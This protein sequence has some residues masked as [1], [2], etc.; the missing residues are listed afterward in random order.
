[1]AWISSGIGARGHKVASWS[2]SRRRAVSRAYGFFSGRQCDQSWVTCPA[3]P[4]PHP[5]AAA[6]RSRDPVGWPPALW[7]GALVPGKGAGCGLAA[8]CVGLS[9]TCGSAPHQGSGSSSSGTVFLTLQLLTRGCVHRCPHHTV[10]TREMAELL[11]T[12]YT[13]LGVKGIS[14][15]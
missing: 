14:E 9:S 6:R 1:M 8:R 4:L 10:E 7:S 3:A 12:V 13:A 15:P 11:S 2:C 5:R